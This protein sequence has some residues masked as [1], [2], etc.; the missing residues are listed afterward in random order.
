MMPM[1]FHEIDEL[2]IVKDERRLAIDLVNVFVFVV[3]SRQDSCLSLI[4]KLDF[5]QPTILKVHPPING[6]TAHTT[7]PDS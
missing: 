6:I 1:S 3:V 5:Y 7:M 2:D 4:M